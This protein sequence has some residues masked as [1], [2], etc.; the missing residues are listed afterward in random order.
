MKYDP[1]SRLN[2]FLIDG[3]IAGICF[4]ASY[5]LRFDGQVPPAAEYQMWVTLPVIILGRGLVH[6]AWGIYRHVW[7]YIS[8]WDAF[9]LELSFITFST[10]LLV[11]RLG[12]PES[13]AL[14]RIPLSVIMLEIGRASCRERV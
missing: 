4:A 12:L 2:Q 8:L 11:L 7:R 6:W 3:T 14:L 5:Y 9:Y 13:L 1:Y 10:I